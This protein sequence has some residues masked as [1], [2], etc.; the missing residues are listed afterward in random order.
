M[1]SQISF[2]TLRCFPWHMAFDKLIQLQSSLQLLNM[3]ILPLMS[4]P[5]FLV[6]ITFDHEASLTT[7]LIIQA[8]TSTSKWEDVR[9]LI[10]D[11]QDFRYWHTLGCFYIHP[12]FLRRD[13]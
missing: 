7:I 9:P 1:T 6:F 8:V 3:W 2:V 12:I 13:G 5:L 11:A 10:E 4:N